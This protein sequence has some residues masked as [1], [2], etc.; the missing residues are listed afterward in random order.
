MA[1]PQRENGYTA[2]ANEI[3]EALAKYRIPGECYQVLNC[4]L[5]S[6]YGWNRKEAELSNNQLS[7]MTGL[8]RQNVIRA[9]KWLESK[10]ILLRIKN[11]STRTKVL[12]FNKNFD[13]WKKYTKRQVG[14]KNDA[15]VRIKN[16]SK[17]ESIPFIVKTIKQSKNFDLF[18]SSY[19]MKKGKQKSSD[20]WEKLKKKNKLPPIENIL[21]AIK[22]QKAEK[23][24]LQN[25][26]KFCPEWKHPTTWLNQGCWDDEVTLPNDKMPGY[27]YR[28]D[29]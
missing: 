24:Y 18:W 7:E 29:G 5:R 11:D 20:V 28:A 22:D 21:K 10:M 17:P 1:S 25:N 9:V 6:T 3:M 15:K 14:I 16:D 13:E 12:K 19:P 23:E 26:G 8:K 4:V 27:I 2:I